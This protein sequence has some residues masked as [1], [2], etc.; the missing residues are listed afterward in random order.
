MRNAGS[1]FRCYPHHFLTTSIMNANSQNV[2]LS[3]L[4]S[5]VLWYDHTHLCLRN[6]RA[7][8]SEQIYARYCSSCI[9]E[10]PVGKVIAVP[11]RHKTL[12]LSRTLLQD[13]T[14]VDAQTDTGQD[15]HSTSAI[16]SCLPH[17]PMNCCG[18]RKDTMI[19]RR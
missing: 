19:E 10:T 12:V 14:D 4:E 13:A 11:I 15:V 8:C 5:S 3:I 9:K 16:A 18:F 17:V 7:I 1:P 6:H 2:S